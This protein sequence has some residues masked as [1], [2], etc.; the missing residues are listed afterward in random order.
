MPL[1]KTGKPGGLFNMKTSV[2]ILLFKKAQ[3][4]IFYFLVH[5]GGPFWKN[6]DLGAWSVPKGE[7]SEGENLLERALIE[8][9]EETGKKIHGDFIALK[10][11]KQK[12]GKTVHA[13]ALEGDLE[14]SGLYS[15][16]ILIDWPP[17]S[18][19]TL[20]IPEV[21]RWEWFDTEEACKKINPAQAEFIA[22]LERVLNDV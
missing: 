12:S 1:S 14:L 3:G 10:P 22:E 9:E 7:A 6:K 19:K 16:T 4:K 18:G 20:E 13:W 21:D 17:R 5:P 2:G 11:I 15:N 8:F